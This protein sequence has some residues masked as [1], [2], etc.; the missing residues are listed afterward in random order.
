M[1]SLPIP[2]IDPMIMPLDDF[3][4]LCYRQRYSVHIVAENK[5]VRLSICHQSW[6]TSDLSQAR[7]LPTAF[8]NTVQECINKFLNGKENN[9]E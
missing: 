4:D 1:S 2:N 5:K 9:C 7:P 6:V 8:G 3:I